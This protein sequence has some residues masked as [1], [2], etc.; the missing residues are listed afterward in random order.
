MEIYIPKNINITKMGLQIGFM[1][2]YMTLLISPTCQEPGSHGHVLDEIIITNWLLSYFTDYTF[3]VICN[4]NTWLV[5][6]KM[7]VC[8][9]TSRSS[10][11]MS[12]KDGLY[13][14]GHCPQNIIPQQWN[15]RTCWLYWDQKA[16]TLINQTTAEMSHQ[17]RIPPS[18]G[19]WHGCSRLH[20][21][22]PFL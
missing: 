9:S 19:R 17:P 4:R 10:R 18:E 15:C 5:W 12:E 6:M 22:F 8:V 7:L 1:P 16:C 2:H 3:L 11:T 20:T 14:T 13:V 21:P